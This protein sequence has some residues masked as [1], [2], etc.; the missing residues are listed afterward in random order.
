MNTIDID[1]CPAFKE[2][3]LQ[4]PIGIDGISCATFLPDTNPQQL[5]LGT[6]GGRV[7]IYDISILTHNCVYQRKWHKSIR[8]LSLLPTTH[9][10]ASASGQGG[11]KL[12]DLESGTKIWMRLKAH[13]NSSISS[14]LTTSPVQLIT[15]DEAG[16]VKVWDVRKPGGPCQKIEQEMVDDVTDSFGAINEMVCGGNQNSVLAALDNGCL[17]VLN[18]RK[19]R[20]EVLSDTLGYSARTL[21]VV[22]NQHRALVGTEEGV[23][24]IFNWDEFELF[25]DRFTLPGQRSIKTSTIGGHVS[26]EKLIKINEDVVAAATDDG[27]ISAVNI[28]PNGR[29]GL[30]G[31][32]H[33][34]EEIGGDCI[35]LAVNP[36]SSLLASVC[37]DST[38][39]DF[40]PLQ[41]W[42]SMAKSSKTKPTLGKKSRFVADTERAEHLAGLL[43][44]T[45]EK[46]EMSSEAQSDSDSD[47]ESGSSSH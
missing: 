16:V 1:T 37:P 8:C 46:E 22:K 38:E 15:G 35:N 7:R 19:G 33:G 23:I 30:I 17:A 41:K 6:T 4:I 20:V 27:C 28:Q 9:H 5:V 36:Q 42:I 13:D 10:L 44:D 39:V 25:A 11:I 32:H 21:V 45:R 24:C 34:S 12:H 18:I 2:F 31:R 14:L 43:P 3:R 26:I 40:W 47:V 29:L